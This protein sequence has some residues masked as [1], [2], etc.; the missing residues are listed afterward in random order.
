MGNAAFLNGCRGYDCFV[1]CHR[2]A[3]E[4]ERAV[5]GVGAVAVD[6]ACTDAAV[7][8]IEG[9]GF[10]LD[11]TGDRPNRVVFHD[12]RCF[13]IAPNNHVRDKTAA[14]RDLQMQVIA[15]DFMGEGNRNKGAGS[16]RRTAL[17]EKGVCQFFPTL[18]AEAGSP[19]RR[20]NRRL[21]SGRPRPRQSN[22]INR[23]RPIRLCLSDTR[24]PHG[25]TSAGT[26]LRQSYRC[27][28]PR[29]CRT[30]KA[31]PMPAKGRSRWGRAVS[32]AT[33]E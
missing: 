32:P 31:F 7:F 27:R 9:L 1:C 16:V 21:L 8:V 13:P 19:A 10:G 2:F 15:A 18:S 20:E 29:R 25:S 4:G 33:N 24:K 12:N 14:P 23:S 3:G 17:R 26:A 6:G 22:P 30:P 11:R 28:E 5:V